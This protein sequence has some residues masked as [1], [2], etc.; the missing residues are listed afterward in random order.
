MEFND[1]VSTPWC[2][3]TATHG[4]PAGNQL[5]GVMRRLL[6]EKLL[7]VL[8]VSITVVAR[9]H[10]KGQEPCWTTEWA[11]CTQTRCVTREVMAG[12]TGKHLSTGWFLK[13]GNIS[14]SASIITLK[15]K[16]HFSHSFFHIPFS[17][18]VVQHCLP[19]YFLIIS[20]HLL[21]W[22]KKREPIP[23]NTL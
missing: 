21:M 17:V 9:S 5:A 12:P 8:F 11:W 20:L 19:S 10:Q 3:T 18:S 15:R 23:R 22:G 4:L 16:H 1:G 7:L 14:R 6:S 13:M 2:S